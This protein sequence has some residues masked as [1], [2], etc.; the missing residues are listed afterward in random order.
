MGTPEFGAIILKGLIKDGYSPVL[1][2]AAPDKPVDRKKIMTSPPVKVIA[3]KY[4]ISVFQPEKII[5]AKCRIQ[6]IK[7]DLIIIAA[8]GQILPKEILEIPEYGC[9]NVHPSLLPKYRG[10]SPIQAVILNGDK[11]AGV[12]IILMDEKTDHG[13]ILSQK[14]VEIEEKETAQILHNR[15]ADAGVRL[16][17]KTIPRWI[18][19][20]IKPKVQNDKN[21]T[22]AKV[23]TRECGKINWKKPAETLE[24]E[25]RAYFPWPGSY[26]F[27]EKTG[28]LTKIK[29]L[30][31][32][33][34][35]SADRI[36]YPVGKVLIVPQNEI[37]IQCGKGFSKKEEGGDFL[38]IEKLQMEGKK[39][40]ASEDFL[41]GHSDFIG[42]ILK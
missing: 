39:E 27:W 15:L 9:L 14:I 7:P 35:K 32:R 21:A 17:L 38:V 8:F 16:L 26:T 42:A 12:T 20:T 33:V 23:L 2:I 3:E 37:G 31:T 40:T 36:R 18:K 24:K 1:I 22:F 6:N 11:K 5:D 28:K 29:I 41:R 4:N 13:P 34:F 25:V 10:S 30:K 19:K